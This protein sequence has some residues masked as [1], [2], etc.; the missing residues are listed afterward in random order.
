VP[1]YDRG[2]GRLWPWTLVAASRA[3]GRW[4]AAI[5]IEA[6]ASAEDR[7]RIDALAQLGSTWSVK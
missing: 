5:A 4:R 2:L 3:W 7:R 6:Q 1:D